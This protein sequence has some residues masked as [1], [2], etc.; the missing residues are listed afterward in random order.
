MLQTVLKI[1][2]TIYV[3]YHDTTETK[4]QYKN[5]LLV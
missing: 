1:A 4:S 2:I 3:V 5:V